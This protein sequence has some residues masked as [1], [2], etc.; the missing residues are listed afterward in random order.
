[1]SNQEKAF[2][3][4]TDRLSSFCPGSFGITEFGESSSPALLTKRR[5]YSITYMNLFIADRNGTVLI[6]GTELPPGCR[7]LLDDHGEDPA[8][9][10]L[11]MTRGANDVIAIS[12]D[13]SPIQGSV[14]VLADV[15][16]TEQSTVAISALF[17]IVGDRQASS[18]L[19]D[20]SNELITHWMLQ[21]RLFD[22]GGSFHAQEQCQPQANS[23]QY[24]E[25]EDLLQCCPER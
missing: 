11:A 19:W 21:N 7:L 1:M 24:N 10:R 20:T 22:K 15:E 3:S 4:M 17:D 12:G 25:F 23:L 16:G 5:V 2:R 8:Y 13:T 9:A 18:I 6:H 14:L